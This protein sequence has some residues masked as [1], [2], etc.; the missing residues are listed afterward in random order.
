MISRQ[1]GLKN[2]VTDAH[3]LPGSR[4]AA[5]SQGRASPILGL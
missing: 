5:V 4:L 1:S 2:E 3:S